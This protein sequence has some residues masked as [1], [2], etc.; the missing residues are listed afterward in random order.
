MSD[1][2]KAFEQITAFQKI[3]TETFA[4]MM[5]TAVLPSQPFPTPEM[6]RQMRGTVFD[7]MG[8][9]W[10][11]F[12]RSPQFL[13]TMKQGMDHVIKFR[14]MSNEV[15]AK[16]RTELQEPT[17]DDVEAVAFAVR[18]IEKRTEAIANELAEIKSAILRQ[19]N[20]RSAQPLKARTHPRIR[21][22]RGA[23][24]RRRATT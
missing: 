23:A 10:D 24:V 12:M 11:E 18:G 19:T 21:S 13:Q 16:V 2:E 9:S 22:T 20:Q 3:W 5:Q 6:G 15:I 14:K 7:A 1:S 17:R 8:K 4:N